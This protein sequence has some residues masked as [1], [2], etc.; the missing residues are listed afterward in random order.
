MNPSCNLREWSTD[1]AR[2]L[3][4]HKGTIQDV[5]GECTLKLTG[6]S[7][8]GC[9]VAPHYRL[10]LYALNKKFGIYRKVVGHLQNSSSP[11]ASLLKNTYLSIMQYLHDV[12]IS[13]LH[14][15]M[16]SADPL[17]GTFRSVVFDYYLWLDHTVIGFH[18]Q[19]RS[20]LEDRHQITFE[21]L[22]NNEGISDPQTD[23][24]IYRTCTTVAYACEVLNM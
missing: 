17:N 12:R 15:C 23:P 24:L 18:E 13:F 21:I 16:N 8:M 4:R 19:A 1:D 22:K 5:D 2:Q 14:D 10:P 20:E 6:Q 7:R 3:L 9:P 11:N